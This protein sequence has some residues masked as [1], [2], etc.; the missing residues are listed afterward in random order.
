MS[1][2]SHE[3]KQFLTYVAHCYYEWSPTQISDGYP[4]LGLVVYFI[5]SDCQ[6]VPS[7]GPCF[8]PD[9]FHFGTH[10]H[11]VALDIT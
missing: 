5:P 10:I 4:H 7:I 1:L 6:K 3:R 11:L 8:L 2:S 9:V